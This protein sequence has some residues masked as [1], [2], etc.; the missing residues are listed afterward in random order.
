[1]SKKVSKTGTL[2]RHFFIDS[3]SMKE[4]QRERKRSH[5]S[6]GDGAV[7]YRGQTIEASHLASIAVVD[8]S[9]ELT[10]YFGEPGLV[11]MMRSAIK[12][13]QLIPLVAIGAADKFGFAD[14]N[15]S[16]MAGSHS[17]SDAHIEVVLEN[18]MKA[19]NDPSMLKCGSHW[20]IGMQMTNSYPIKGED[21]DP[22][23]HNCSGKHSGF[24][25]LTRFLNENIDRY[26]DPETNSQKMVKQ[27]IADCCECSM[28]EMPLGI[29][30]CSAPNYPL[31]ISNLALG[32]M[33]L[34]QAHG[35]GKMPVSLERIRKAMIAYPIL[36]S[37]ENRLDYNLMRSFP[38]KVVC[39]GGAEG[40]QGIGFVDP[41]M[42]I[43]IKIHDGSARTLGAICL[44]L[45]KQ[46]GLVKDIDDF[47]FLRQY[48]QVEVH[49]NAGLVTGRME[50]VFTLKKV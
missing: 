48:H 28:D 19:S 43:A 13:F 10:H 42:G 26:L 29:D 31:P 44:E 2:F 16:I 46:L 49:N 41:P 50:S 39:K 36:F 12:P 5:A 45:L 27:A 17:G 38:G 40:L 21:K 15:L 22:I 30:G 47:P 35:G 1:V 3:L 18:L 7:L 37:G 34:A 33:K 4:Q 25:A 6:A 8:Q 24:L 32:F 23:R 20:P 14:H 9:G 11:T